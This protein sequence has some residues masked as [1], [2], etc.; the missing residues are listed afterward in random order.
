[1]VACEAL[2]EATLEMLQKVGTVAVHSFR[3]F[4]VSMI[5]AAGLAPLQLVPLYVALIS[6]LVMNSN[7][8]AALVKDLFT[9]VTNL[10]I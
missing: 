3:V 5:S 1:M 8:V 4:N 7:L 10:P 2:R 9:W 6:A